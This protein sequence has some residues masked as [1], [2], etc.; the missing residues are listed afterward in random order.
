MQFSVNFHV[1]SLM[2]KKKLTKRKKSDLESWHDHEIFGFPAEIRVF[3]KTT[4]LN[5]G[6]TI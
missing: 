2:R 6:Y 3:T 1:E 4:T 5:H